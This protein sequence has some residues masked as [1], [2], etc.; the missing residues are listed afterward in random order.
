[1]KAFDENTKISMGIA[2]ALAGGIVWL[3]Q[4]HIQT[5]ANAEEIRSTREDVKQIQDI[6]SDLLVIKSDLK[7][8]LRKVEGGE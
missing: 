5:V 6:K 7:R 8:V 1:M 2:I 3:T 4:L